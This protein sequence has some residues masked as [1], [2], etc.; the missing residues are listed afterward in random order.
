MRAAVIIPCYNEAAT[1]ARVVASVRGVCTPIVVDDAGTDGSGRLA[2]EAGAEVVRHERNRGYD[3]ALQSGF[4]RARAM[5][6][7]AVATFDADGQHDAGMLTRMLEPV[8]LGRV[9]LVI[10]V[11]PEFARLAEAAFGAYTRLRYGVAD[12]LCGMKAYDMG[13][14]VEHGCF[15]S[16]GSV[17]TELAL[18]ALRSGVAFETVPVPVFA[19]ADAPRFGSTLRANMKILR[20][21]ALGMLRDAGAGGRP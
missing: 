6:I 2:A 11:R 14:F 10:G 21:M 15:D 13:L 1:I 7:G 17:G 3:G 9:R 16:Y 8:L 4:E 19:R 20:A 5:G 18:A 12:I